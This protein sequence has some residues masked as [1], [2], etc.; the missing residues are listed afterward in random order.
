MLGFFVGRKC[1]GWL[2]SF[3]DMVYTREGSFCGWFGLPLL[4]GELLTGGLGNSRLMGCF[5]HCCST[6]CAKTDTSSKVVYC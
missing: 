5:F 2:E 3:M 4:K 1:L 6:L